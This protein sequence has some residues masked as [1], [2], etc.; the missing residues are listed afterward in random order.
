MTIIFL[1]FVFIIVAFVREPLGRCLKILRLICSYTPSIPTVHEVR[2]CVHTTRNGE[3][4][5]S[6]FGF[7]PAKTHYDYN[8]NYRYDR[9]IAPVQYNSMR[10]ACRSVV[11]RSGRSF[12][13]N[14]RNTSRAKTIAPNNGGRL[15][16]TIN[17]AQYIMQIIY[18]HTCVYYLCAR[19]HYVP[20]CYVSFM[21]TYALHYVSAI[22]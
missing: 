11:G 1:K 15:A 16:Q 22:T 20:Y 6:D 13:R 3:G 21:Y 10:Y 7:A 17:N 8:N 2:L 4:R 12:Y 19:T 9:Y 14:T 5:K 18:T